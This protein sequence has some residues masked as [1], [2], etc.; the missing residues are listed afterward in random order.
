MEQAR[1]KGK[2]LRNRRSHACGAI[3]ANNVFRKGNKKLLDSA[4]IT[5]ATDEEL[6]DG[7]AAEDWRHPHQRARNRSHPVSRYVFP[8]GF[9]SLCELACVPTGCHGPG[10]DSVGQGGVVDCAKHL[11]WRKIFL[12]FRF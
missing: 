9:R 10:R 12:H 1:D 4:A 3:S 11:C 6:N 5:N 7:V 2:S 8:V